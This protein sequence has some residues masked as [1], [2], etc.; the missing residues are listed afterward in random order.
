MTDR[1]IDAGRYIF[2]G[3]AAQRVS[4]V[5]TTKNKVEFIGK[6]LDEAIQL[7]GPEDE[8]I[9]V[10]GASTDG[11]AEVIDSRRDFIDTFISEPDI[12]CDHAIN[13][14]M[15]VA[16]GKYIKHLTDDDEFFPEAMEQAITLL[17]NNPQVDVLVCGGMRQLGVDIY[18]FYI[19]PGVNYGKSPEDVF[20][21]GVCG[22]GFVIRRSSLAVTGLAN[23]R[24][25]ATDAE[26]VAKA[27][28][29]GALV[30]FCRVNLFHHPIY[31]HGAFIGRR[32]EWEHDM[33]RIVRQYC[34]LRF[35]LKYR[36]KTA[37][38]R[39]RML[40]PPALA[41]N[42]IVKGLFAVLGGK[43]AGD[44]KSIGEPVWDGGLS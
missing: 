1:A 44:K 22:C 25:V 2:N 32:Q 8:L 40:A 29:N 10:D 33:K 41:V 36:I 31:E 23:P 26:F 34:S 9:V 18:P 16:R 38:L 11:T 15:L 12:S 37:I 7:V 3:Q 4:F 30:R 20:N 13:K 43:R 27:I 6:A 17:E 24:G 21:H 19:P 14:G 42:Q 5:L 39:N 35:Y 28:C